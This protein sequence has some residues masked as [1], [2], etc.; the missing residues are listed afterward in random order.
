M[1]FC[2]MESTLALSSVIMI[3]VGSEIEEAADDILAADGQALPSDLHVLRRRRKL[4]RLA[5]MSGVYE[6][7][8][9]NG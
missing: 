9:N 3:K 7:V 4:W 6:M 5:R 1:A 2:R 8:S